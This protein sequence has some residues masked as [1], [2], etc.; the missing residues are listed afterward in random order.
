MLLLIDFFSELNFI[1]CNKLIGRSFSYDEFKS[2][3]RSKVEDWFKFI[4][5]GLKCCT[6][7]EES[8]YIAA[9]EVR[10]LLKVVF[11]DLQ[12][13]LLHGSF[14]GDGYS[15]LIVDG[16]FDV[17]VGCFLLEAIEAYA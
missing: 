14:S 12:L 1:S 13:N 9:F 6:V 17:V 2:T 8:L 4:G 15:I 3:A 16:F 10:S 5:F 7:V 11:F